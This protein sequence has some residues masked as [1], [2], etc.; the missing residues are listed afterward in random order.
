MESWDIPTNRLPNSTPILTYVE[1]FEFWLHVTS[2]QILV[3]LPW[4]FSELF[5]NMLRIMKLQIFVFPQI[6]SDAYCIYPNIINPHLIDTIIDL[7]FYVQTTWP[8]ILT[9]ITR[10]QAQITNLR[11]YVCM[12]LHLVLQQNVIFKCSTILMIMMCSRCYPLTPSLLRE[13]SINIISL[14]EK[15]KWK[16]EKCVCAC[17]PCCG[18]LFSDNQ[19]KWNRKTFCLSKI[20]NKKEWYLDI[21]SLKIIIFCQCLENF[22]PAKPIYLRWSLIYIYFFIKLKY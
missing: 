17:M 2:P 21:S 13:D 15:Y 18:L 12:Q 11:S 3:S 8:I 6:I 1:S 10:N 4:W 5:E 20:T 7:Q 19:R 9:F 22:I 14:R 16:K